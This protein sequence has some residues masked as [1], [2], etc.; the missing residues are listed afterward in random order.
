MAFTVA[1]VNYF[2]LFAITSNLQALK[3]KMVKLF[4]AIFIII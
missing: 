3:L 4:Q 1:I 2:G